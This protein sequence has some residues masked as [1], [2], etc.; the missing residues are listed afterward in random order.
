MLRH[1][2]ISELLEVRDGEGTATARAHVEQC[3]A[4]GAELDRLHQRVAALRA[5]PRH[6]PPRDRWPAVREAFV[7]ARRRRRWSY[8]S[9]AGLAA[10]AG[11]VLFVGVNTPPRPA[12][13]ASA[14]E[15]IASLVEESQQLERVLHSYNRQGRVV[16]GVT[17][18]AI[19]ELEDRIAVVDVGIDRAQLQ[20]APH[21]AVA[22]LWRRRVTLM[23]R[24]VNTHVQPVTYVGY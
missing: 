16:N 15:E 22:D 6:S 4:C 13:A 11:L 21:E 3:E 19:A 18:A 9:W 5:L 20:A 23:D 1:C 7:S 12:V 2:T 17:A 10:A 24:L 14:P 8:T